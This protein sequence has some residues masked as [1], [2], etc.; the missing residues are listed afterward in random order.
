MIM[1]A[2]FLTY[3]TGYNVKDFSI[4]TIFM[5]GLLELPLF[6]NYQTDIGYSTKQIACGICAGFCLILGQTLQVYASSHGLAGPCVALSQIQG[7]VHFAFNAM[8][9]G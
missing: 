5:M 9:F 7:V 4:D 2:K 6:I 3:K 1:F 8:V